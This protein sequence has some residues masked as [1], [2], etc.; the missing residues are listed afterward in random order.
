M[1]FVF[2]SLGG[3]FG[4][5]GRYGISLIPI[6]SGFPFLT[7]LTNIIGALLIGVIVGIVSDKEN[8]SQNTVLFWKTGVCGGFTTFSTFSLET[9]DLFEK[10]SYLT[11]S[12]YAVLSV[13]FCIAGVF[14][15]KKLVVLLAL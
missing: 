6:K 1:E 12:L 11:G 3:A 9:Y 13:L 2:V 7:L 4:A 5:A 8:V 14:F 15:G 10:G